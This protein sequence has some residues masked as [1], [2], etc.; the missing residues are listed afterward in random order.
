LQPG[1][2]GIEVVGPI[3]APAVPDSDELAKAEGHSVAQRLKNLEVEE[4]EHL[5]DY[6]KQVARRIERLVFG[7]LIA[8]LGLSLLQGFSEPD[9]FDL[10]TPFLVTLAGGTTTS[11]LGVFAILANYLYPKK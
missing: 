8:L 10:P 11:V 1:L 3:N 5:F 9:F 4:A 2:G 7:W 6:K